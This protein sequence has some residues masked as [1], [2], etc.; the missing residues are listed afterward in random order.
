MARIL[1]TGGNGFIGAEL[2]R[3]CVARGDEVTVLVRPE[4]DV[5]RL[6]GCFGDLRCHRVRLVDRDAL[7][8][9]FAAARPE[10]VFHLAATTR[11]ETDPALGDLDR[12]VECNVTP[13]FR[14]VQAA[15][16]AAE[17]PK[18]F[19]RTGTIAEYGEIE[20]PFSEAA[21]EAPTSVYGAAQVAGTQF[22]CA[23]RARLPFPAVTARLALTYGPGQSQEFMVPGTI[24]A[25][26][27]GAQ[28]ELRRP[29]D[30]RDLIH[31][32][33]A[34]SGLLA[35]EAGAETCPPVI[36]IASGHHHSILSVAFL[37]A[38]RL[39]R[40]VDALLLGAQDE[41]VT[42]CCDPALAAK[43]LGWA[44]KI[45]LETGLERTV[46]WE[47]ANWSAAPGAVGGVA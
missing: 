29:A 46:D 10:T 32:D 31:V 42:L 28:A 7:A 15:A 39:G 1:I 4:S 22:L 33:D 40:D 43:T 47:A 20:A 2:V 12:A 9:V 11:F 36:N 19:I 17:P 25:L 8:G 38:R 30:R 13:L 21:R 26:L 23:L 37:I 27:S 5:T 44:A 34:V 18:R 16:T 6:S 45:G 3:R 35:V 24:R 14:V 41:E